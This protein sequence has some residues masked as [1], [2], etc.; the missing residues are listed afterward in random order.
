MTK[1]NKYIVVIASLFIFGCTVNHSGRKYNHPALKNIE[2][3]Q[4]TKKQHQFLEALAIGIL[5]LNGSCITI[6]KSTSII[7]PASFYLDFEN[8]KVVI[9]DGGEIVGII[10]KKFSSGGGST[11]NI[12]H[13]PI[14]KPIKCKSNSY[15]LVGE[16]FKLVN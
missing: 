12:N 14:T 6:G 2:F 5:K 7:F 1:L 8:D 10:G 9:K 15:F 11:K 3:L 16:D 4:Y 13:L